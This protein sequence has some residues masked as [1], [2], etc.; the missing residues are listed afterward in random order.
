[1][2]LHYDINDIKEDNFTTYNLCEDIRC[3]KERVAE[4]EQ[5]LLDA[6]NWLDYNCVK[7]P[8]LEDVIKQSNKV[9]SIA[10]A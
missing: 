4:L 7:V 8:L 9:R 10:N 2:K 5:A 3:L 6:A 1:M